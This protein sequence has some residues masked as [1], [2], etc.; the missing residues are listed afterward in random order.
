MKPGTCARVVPDHRRVDSLPVQ[1]LSLDMPSAWEFQVGSRDVVVAIMDDGFHY[2]HHDLLANIWRNPGETGTGADGVPRESNGVDDDGNGYVDDVN[3]W[4]FVF[5]DPDPDPYVFDGMD[6]NR[7]Q[8]FDHGTHALGIIGAAGND[9]VGIRGTNWRIS[10]MMLKVGAQGIRRGEVDRDKADRIATAIRYAVDNG[11]RVINWSGWISDTAAAARDTVRAAIR[12]AGER[13]V[14]LVIAAGNTPV[15][16]DD[17]R[18]CRYPIC[19]DE[20]N[21]IAVGELDRTGELLHIPEE[22]RTI[23]S[24]YGTRRVQIATLG[25][26]LSTSIRDGN[27]N[28]IWTRGTSNAAPVVTGVIA[29]VLASDPSLTTA[30]AIRIVL[31]SARVD[32]RL[33]GKIGGARALDP[34]AAVRAARALPR[35]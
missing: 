11:A 28:Y 34:A 13:D 35:R 26:H 21:V 29:L 6:R 20:P 18:N 33:E 5:A 2:R 7:I 3:G 1:W 19:F 8:P 4:D 32:P 17:D 9:G 24:T 14:F 30:E 27:S 31:D 25:E 12:Y 10:M 16:I 23:G 22:G 15:D